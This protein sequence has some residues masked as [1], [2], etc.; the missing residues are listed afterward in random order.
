MRRK[1]ESARSRLAPLLPL[2]K[3]RRF[4]WMTSALRLLRG[5]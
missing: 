4:D 1:T 3:A 5:P 2:A